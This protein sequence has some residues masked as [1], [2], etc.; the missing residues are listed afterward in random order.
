MVRVAQ[1]PQPYFTLLSE[2]PPTWRAKFPYLYPPGTAWPSYT[3]GHWVPFTSS[4]LD[5][6]LTT[7]RDTVEV[8]WPNLEGHVPVYIY[9]SGTGWPSPKSKSKVTFSIIFLV[10]FANSAVRSS[11][12]VRCKYESYTQPELFLKEF[13][14]VTG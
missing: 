3:P 10:T 14:R 8:F 12:L 6:P 13:N 1:N 5:S 4:L 9:P 7:R 2:T 11:V